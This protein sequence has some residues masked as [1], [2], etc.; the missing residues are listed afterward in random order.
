V[1]EGVDDLTL[2]RAYEPTLRLTLGEYFLPVDV[3]EYV[4]RCTLWRHEPE[5]DQTALAGPGDLDLAD[6]ADLGSRYDGLPLSLSGLATLDARRDRAKAWLATGRPRFRAARRLA[7]VGLLGRIVDTLS[8]VSLLVR[9]AVPG[10]SAVTALAI[11]RD[12]LEPGGATYYGRVLRDAPW[13]VLQYWYFYSFNN[14]R[15]GFSGVN[16]HE[17]DWEQVTIYLDATRFSDGLPE[18]RWVV[19]SAHDETG[20]DLRRRW[21]DPDLE[22]V[23]GRHPVVYAGAGSH[24][25]AYLPGDYLITVEPPRLRGVVPAFRR[26]AKVVTPWSRA[27]QGEG[28]GIPYVDYARGDGEAIGPGGDREWRAVPIEDST[29]WVRDY[30]GLWGHD[31]RDRLGGERGPAGPRYER[32]GTVR[33]SWGDPVGWA[34]LAK[35]SPNL[36]DEEEAVRRRVEE[37]DAEIAQLGSDVDAGRS[38]LRRGAA[39]LPAAE[40]RAELAGHEEEVSRNRM[41]QVHLEDERRGLRRVL[42]DGLT[43]GGP[44]DHL[45]HRRLPIVAAERTRE[46]LLGLWSILS[47]PLMLVVLAWLFFPD[48]PARLSAAVLAIAAILSVEAFARGYLAAFVARLLIALLVVALLELYALQ[49]QWATTA[50][51]A[52]LALAVLFVNVRDAV[53]H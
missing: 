37:L 52:L 41:L 2:L 50:V 18:P 5:G 22:L 36:A 45:R 4:R 19:Y 25:G 9:G 49:W 46:R 3:G 53:R 26:I 42:A 30:K 39:G 31:T 48:A 23:D 35:V 21:D 7:Q 13:V 8:R 28:L 44:H 34:G 1:S 38:A 27:A 43:T 29:P 16:E 10:G 14:W 24:S 6:L 15:S 20:D 12:H 51:L 40:A 33:E 32:D 17:A 11:Q 47:T